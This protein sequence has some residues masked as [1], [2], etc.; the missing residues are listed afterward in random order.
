[1]LARRN[2]VL[3]VDV[4]ASEAVEKRKPGACPPEKSLAGL[5]VAAAIGFDESGPAITVARD[6]THRS[7]LDRSMLAIQTLDQ[8]MPSSVETQ[9]LRLVDDA[10]AVFEA[11]DQHRMAA[12]VRVGEI[13]F[14]RRNP[15][16]RV[17]LKDVLT[18][19]CKIG[20]EAQDEFARCIDPLPS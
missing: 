15:A 20:I 18:D 14:D 6:R 4:G 16:T 10:T 1:M 17:G 2:H 5:R 19:R 7:K 8:C 13:A 11:H 3:L 9:I 12:I